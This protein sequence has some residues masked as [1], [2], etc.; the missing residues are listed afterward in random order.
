MHKSNFILRRLP[1]SDPPPR[2]HGCRYEVGGQSY[3]EG[4]SPDA[5]MTAAAKKRGVELSGGS[6]PMRPKDLEEFD[7]IVGMVSSARRFGCE[8]V[9]AVTV[10][11]L[12]VAEVYSKISILET[13][14]DFLLNSIL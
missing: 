2:L 1:F 6:R 3:H 8:V 11:R 9:W 10:R 12:N 7:L 4:D 13:R 14:T 5:R